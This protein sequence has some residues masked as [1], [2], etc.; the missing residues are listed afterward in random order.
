MGRSGNWESGSTKNCYSPFLEDG[1]RQILQSSSTNLVL[2]SLS[3]LMIWVS[4]GWVV[5]CLF[6]RKR[7]LKKASSGKQKGEREGGE[8]RLSYVDY[9]ERG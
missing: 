1:V 5:R 6:D 8:K 7:D 4:H 3:S 9:I 2:S